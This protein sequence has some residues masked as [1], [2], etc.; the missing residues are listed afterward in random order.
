MK[1][2]VAV[3]LMKKKKKP[4]QDR[5][6][7]LTKLLRFLSK[8]LETFE[9][10]LL[11]K[12]D[13]P[14]DAEVKITLF[15]ALLNYINPIQELNDEFKDLTSKKEKIKLLSCRNYR[16]ATTPYLRFI[17]KNSKEL[18]MDLNDEDLFQDWQNQNT[19]TTAICR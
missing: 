6:M 14:I 18:A 12:I 16:L 13:D 4:D 1:E 19:L 11:S 7:A 15:D 2:V 5:A 8:N 9:D 10:S 3:K 17:K